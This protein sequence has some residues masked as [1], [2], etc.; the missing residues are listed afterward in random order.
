MFL[1][2][3]GNSKTPSTSHNKSVLRYVNFWHLKGYNFKMVKGD[4]QQTL[5]YWYASP[6]TPKPVEKNRITTFDNWQHFECNEIC[7]VNILITER[8]EFRNA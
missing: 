2:C 5:E 6:W 1:A 4:S 3:Q 8:V 7:V